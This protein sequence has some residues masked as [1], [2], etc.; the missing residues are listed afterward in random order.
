MFLE[1]TGF[2]DYSEE[3]G[4]GVLKSIKQNNPSQIVIAFSAHSYDFSKKKFWDMAD[5]A[6]DKP[7]GFLEMK[8]VLDS[9]IQSTFNAHH[10]AKK[11]K[12]KIISINLSKNQ[13]F[14]IEKRIVNH[15]SKNKQLQLDKELEIIHNSLQ[16]NQV[17]NMLLRFINLYTD[18]EI[19]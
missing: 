19:E 9:I 2:K 18:Y 4:F 17:K 10:D 11:L 8:E 14:V 13:L 3:D 12:E 16:R 15:I 7:A 6:V 1:D 5:E